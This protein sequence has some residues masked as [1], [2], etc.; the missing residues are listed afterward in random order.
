MA[1]EHATTGIEISIDLA[2]H[3]HNAYLAFAILINGGKKTNWT[4]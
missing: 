3:A 4:K 2:L 1:A